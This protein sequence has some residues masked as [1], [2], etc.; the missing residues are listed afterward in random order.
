MKDNLILG[1]TGG[2]Y[3]R[4]VNLWALGGTW[5]GNQILGGDTFGP[6]EMK[7]KF[8]ARL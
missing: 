8:L 7:L 3:D 6:S 2:T 5:E 1:E 4:I